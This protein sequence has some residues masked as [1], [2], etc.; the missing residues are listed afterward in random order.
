MLLDAYAVQLAWILTL[1]FLAALGLML[2]FGPH[3]GLFYTSFALAVFALL[4]H[5]A[6]AFSHSCPECGKHPTIQGFTPPHSS[7]ADDGDNAWARVVRDVLK[8]RAF[9]CFHCGS[10]FSVSD[11]A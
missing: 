2:F 7:V 9:T 1:A 11:A 4:L 5:V 8:K 6:L 3:M 10:R